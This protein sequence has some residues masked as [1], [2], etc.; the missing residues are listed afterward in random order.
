LFALRSATFP[1]VFAALP[2][3]ANA[4]QP[5]RNPVLR[6][7]AGFRVAQVDAVRDDIAHVAHLIDDR[8]HAD[9]PAGDHLTGGR[10]LVEVP[11]QRARQPRGAFEH[12]LPHLQLRDGLVLT[13]LPEIKEDAL[14]PRHVGRWGAEV[15]RQR[16]RARVLAD[17]L[18]DQRPTVPEGLL[19]GLGQLGHAEPELAVVGGGLSG[20]GRGAHCRTPITTSPSAD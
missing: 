15:V 13:A 7:F 9:D 8:D 16:P 20:C 4:G 14:V 18:T 6:V 12:L 1:T 19:R 3:K 10:A 17:V 11:L 2:N 5:K